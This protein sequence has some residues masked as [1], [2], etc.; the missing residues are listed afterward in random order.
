MRR[1]INKPRPPQVL[2]YRGLCL[3]LESQDCLWLNLGP[4]YR[5][6][7]RE[8]EDRDIC[9][10]GVHQKRVSLLPGAGGASRAKSIHGISNSGRINPSHIN[11]QCHCRGDV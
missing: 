6:T 1:F 9:C 8:S 11:T 5:Q 7:V 10:P 2:G 4:D 3:L